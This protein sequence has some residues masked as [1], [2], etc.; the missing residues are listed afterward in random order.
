M[1][2]GGKEEERDGKSTT[3]QDAKSLPDGAVGDG[4]RLQGSG[5]SD[6]QQRKI[7]IEWI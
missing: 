6:C 2:T 4:K 7:P 5:S 3:E 1:R